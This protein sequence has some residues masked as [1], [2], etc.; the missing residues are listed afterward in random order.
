MLHQ[1]IATI[2]G[3]TLHTQ[4]NACRITLQQATVEYNDML[5]K[6]VEYVKNE[7]EP[8]VR[9]KYTDGA[10]AIGK[11]VYDRKIILTKD[12]KSLELRR[13]SVLCTWRLTF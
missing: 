6:K 11:V 1:L 7:V 12:N 3:I 8:Y 4:V 5:N 2:C 13:D 10:F 9:N